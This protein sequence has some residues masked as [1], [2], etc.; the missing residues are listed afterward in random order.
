MDKKYLILLLISI[1]LLSG[2]TTSSAYSLEKQSTEIYIE[3]PLDPEPLT[4]TITIYRY[5]IAGDIK[6]IEIEINLEQGKD[7]NDLI[8]EKC[9]ELLIEDEEFQE[10]SKL[11][12]SIGIL[13]IVKSR[14]RGIHI[15]PSPRLKFIYCRYPRDSW[16]TTTILPLIGRNITTIRGPHSVMSFGFVGLKWWIER[17]SILGFFLRTGYIGFS[18]M[19]VVRKL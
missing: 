4:R 13:S 19:T 2:L 1:I 16:A 9:E 12:T 8:S 15:K 10:I 5:G 11:K 6:P 3:K 17:I 18:A 14:G 7:I